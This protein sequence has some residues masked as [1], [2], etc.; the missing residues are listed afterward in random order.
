MTSL[1]LEASD[2]LPL[3]AAMPG[4][5]VVL[6]LKPAPEEPVLLR[7]YSLSGEPSEARWRLGVKR[8]PNGA[9]GAYVETGLKVGDVI[10]ASAPRG[11]FTLKQGDGPVVLLSAG[12]GS[13]PVL[14]MLHALAASGSRRE[15]WW[16]HGA[17]N[18]AEHAFAAEVQALLKS[19]PGGHSHIRYSAPGP[20]D[21]LAVDFDGPGRLDAQRPQ[22]AGRASRRGFLS[23]RTVRLHE[24]PDRGS[25]ELGRPRPRGCT[26]RI[27]ARV[28]R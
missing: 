17:R 8:E 6:R 25:D 11:A 23:V 10:D 21:R 28:P 9:A 13:T 14:A 20:T 24:R 19:L 3:V 2:G 7:S 18:R 12:I 15:V 22:D 27:S 4:Q 16:I 5:F 1:A 26:V